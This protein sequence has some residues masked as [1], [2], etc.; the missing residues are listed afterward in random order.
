MKFQDPTEKGGNAGLF[1]AFCE[2]LL[3]SKGRL[4]Q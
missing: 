2:A 1:L 3:A 4:G